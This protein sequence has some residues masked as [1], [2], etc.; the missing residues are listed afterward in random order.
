MCF[1]GMFVQYEYTV[2]HITLIEL[3]ARTDCKH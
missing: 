2:T 1:H 3:T